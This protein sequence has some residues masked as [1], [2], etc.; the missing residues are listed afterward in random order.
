MPIVPCSTSGTKPAKTTPV[1]SRLELKPTHKPVKNHYAALRQQPLRMDDGLFSLSASNL[2]KGGERWTRNGL[3]IHVASSR[4]Q[5]ARLCVDGVGVRRAGL[6]FHER[7]KQIPCV[8]YHAQCPSLSGRRGFRLRLP[9]AT[10][11]ALHPRL[12][13]DGLSALSTAAFGP[14]VP[15]AR[16]AAPPLGRRAKNGGRGAPQAPVVGAESPQCD[17]L[18]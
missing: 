9:G 15:R 12:S 3:P 1:K 11:Y 16:R 5:A 4:R 6:T 18:G 13:Q 17:S 14:S 2:E 10:R 7:P 8:S